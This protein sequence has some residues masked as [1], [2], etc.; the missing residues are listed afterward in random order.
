[1]KTKFKFMI[2]DMAV[3]MRAD[4]LDAA[5]KEETS[6]AVLDRWKAVAEGV[7]RRHNVALVAAGE[8]AIPVCP[9]N[10]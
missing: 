3:E 7:A 2:A 1:M 8:D 9:P 6:E 4:Y 10:C 5:R